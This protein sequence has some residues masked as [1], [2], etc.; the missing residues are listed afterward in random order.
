MVYRKNTY[1]SGR[2]GGE[3]KR[4]ISDLLLRELK[5]PAFGGLVSVS[6][7]NAA[8]D[9]SFATVFVTMLS[10]TDEA[11][12]EEKSAV[13]GAF[14]KAKGFIR[15]E[16]GQRLGIRHAPDLRFIFDTSEEYGRHIE[17]IL[18]EL[19]IEK[20]P[21]VKPVNTAAEIAD[22]LDEA[23]TV[24]IFPH[25]NMDGD[26]LGSAVAL[27]LA[28][29]GKGKDCAVV[30]SEK[31]PDNIAFI[32]YGCTVRAQDAAA[33]D[34]LFAGYDLAVLMDVGEVARLDDRGDLFANGDE[35]MCFDHHI[36]SKAIYDYNDID[37]AAS[38]TAE[39]IYEA[40][41]VM[42]VPI[43]IRIAT[44]LYVGIVTDTGR[45]QYTNTT[46]HTHRI[47]AE[48]MEDGMQ[49][50][51][52]STEIYQNMRMEKIL[53]ENAVV[54]TMQTVAGG[55]GVVAHMTKEMLSD[56]GAMEEETE[57]IAEKLRGIRGVEV[58]AFI[59][60]AENGRTKGSMRSK[61]QY[62]VAEL[63]SQ[64]GGGGH[65]RAAGFTS[66]KPL[67]DVVAEVKRILDKTL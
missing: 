65:I 62:D 37:T 21:R 36:S 32:E 49:P 25:E 1:R 26:T 55:R 14:E 59:R 66:E 44:A 19:G 6:A 47:V 16:I 2:I 10:T 34:V 67:M 3:I 35:T 23:E 61:R 38:A 58:S 20:T 28:L 9:G 64:F 7:V 11:T 43:D 30:I 52:V 53:L 33:D 17:H 63:A 51:E 8:K 45:F 18:G 31:I 12:D 27:C 57:G 13:L 40:L 54:S 39:L 15:H 5:D 56:T 60:E 48:L 29:R 22:A 50:N 4:I 46:P 41:R 24:R 42:N